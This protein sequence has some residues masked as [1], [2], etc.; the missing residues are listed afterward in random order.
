MTLNKKIFLSDE[1]DLLKIISIIFNNKLKIL[2]ITTF[3]LLTTF[4]YQNITGTTK[5][6]YKVM[7]EIKTD[8]EMNTFEYSN[9][10]IYFEKVKTVKSQSG[11]YRVKE[12][13]KSLLYDYLIS[14]IQDQSLWVKAV[15]SFD[16]LKK[17]D[18]VD[19]ESYDLAIKNFVFKIFVVNNNGEWSIEHVTD[20]PDKWIKFLVYFSKFANNE[21]IL[22]IKKDY[23]KFFF[24]KKNLLNLKVEDYDI[25]IKNAL[26]IYD[27][28]T[29]SYLAYLTEQALI[30]RELDI[31][32]STVPSQN[33]NSETGVIT[34]LTT[35]I[36]YYMRGW[37]MIEKEIDLIKSRTDKS[38][39]V[40]G[41]IALQQGRKELTSNK[42]IEILE[43]LF[44]EL[45][46]FTDPENFKAGRIMAQS[47]QLEN[48]DKIPMTLTKMLL[49]TGIISLILSISYV[50][51]VNELKQR[52]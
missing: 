4:V 37:D 49:I 51:I 16:L 50:L 28:K 13:N 30:A 11:S 34:S 48:I 9:F 52:K 26:T 17:E 18:Y 1:I 15:D 32:Q 44:K 35:D 43:N 21:V 20:E 12:L 47:S 45:P 19:L 23:E 40:D 6:R 3:A 27:N 33:F 42:D 24:L 46:L 25:A 10:N 38:F 31:K 29:E 39:F 41:M 14:T 8:A 5:L 22:K 7:T 2:L 36:P